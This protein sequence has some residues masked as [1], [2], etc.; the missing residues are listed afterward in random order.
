M[1][2]TARSNVHV[3]VTRAR[4]RETG[5]RSPQRARRGDFRERS[6]TSPPTY[7][8]R[9][10]LN[11]GAMSNQ[12]SRLA[13]VAIAFGLA[14]AASSIAP[15]RAEAQP[16]LLV[17]GLA[18]EGGGFVADAQGAL[19]GAAV[20]LGV[21]PLPVLSIYL[22]SHGLIGA[23]SAGPHSGHVAGVLW[24]TLMLGLH[25]GVFEIAAGPS[26]DFAWSCGDR[27]GCYEGA[28]LFG[29]DGRVALHFGG[30]VLSADVHPTWVRD[31]V[32]VG[33]VGGL[34]WQLL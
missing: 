33:L 17:L 15:G 24:N 21:R 11:L 1:I 10:L 19:G 23:L 26:I 13:A 6:R 14:V 7:V 8:A 31:G 34:G 30:F 9:T 18:A 25:A 22:Q 29:L 28:P 3:H 16:K 12:R 5:A 20:R 27:Q 4:A 2:K 32:V